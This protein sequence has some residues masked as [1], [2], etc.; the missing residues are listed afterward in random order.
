MTDKIHTDRKKRHRPARILVSVIA[1]L[2][3]MLI[4]LAVI[5][6]GVV[7]AM[8][9]SGEQK[10][11]EM[12]QY[13]A[14]TLDVEDDGEEAGEDNLPEEA[15]Q[16][17]KE[18]WVR[19]NGGVYE[20]NEDILTFLFLGIDKMGKV[21]PNP[22]GVSG[23][24]ADAIFLVAADPD[25]KKLSL[26]GVNRDTMV[27]IKMAGGSDSDV[28]IT[29][30]AQL[31]TQHGFGD[32]MEESCELTRDAVSELFY[33][34]PIHG[35]ASFNMGGV[36]V[37]NDALGGVELPVLGTDM[38]S[39]NKKWTEGTMV[40]LMGTDAFEYVHYRDPEI[41]EGSRMRL[42]RQ[43]Q[44][45]GAFVQKAVEATKKDLMLPVT[46][47]NNL[48]DY[49]VTD[50]GIDEMAYLAGELV[51]YEFSIDNIHT[52]EGTTEQ[53]E[54]EQFY[55]DKKALRDLILDVFYREVDLD[56]VQ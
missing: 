15:G 20:Y 27:D 41:F 12:G 30:N 36:A 9:A 8:R 47:Y 25:S 52:L 42:E 5:L 56:A 18:G 28:S 1:V 2:F 3:L 26:I 51:G 11:R 21:A 7:R 4:L 17:W 23:G 31:A 54:F 16:V 29:Y 33:N 34:L 48:K 45:L 6:Y 13:H 44:Y 40:T 53:G 32:G 22:D 38:T 55:P 50:I 37:L 19:Y 10:L 46:L 39:F 35:Y 43:K 24:Q 14:I 49:V